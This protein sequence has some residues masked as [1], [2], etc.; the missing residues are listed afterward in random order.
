MAAAPPQR[1]A[2]LLGLLPAPTLESLSAFFE[3]LPFPVNLFHP[4]GTSAFV[5]SAFVAMIQAAAPEYSLLRPE[6]IVE[7]YNILEDPVVIASGRLAGWQAAFAGQTTHFPMIAQPIA[8]IRQNHKMEGMDLVAFYQDVTAFPILAPS[9][10]RVAFVASILITRQ[11]VKGRAEITRGM[12]YLEAHWR[13]PFDADAASEAAGFSVT[14]FA[15]EFKKYLGV[16]PREYHLQYRMERLK[17]RLRDPTVSIARAFSDCGMD[18]SGWHAQSFKDRIGLTPSE[19]RKRES[20]QV[21][22]LTR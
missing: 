20:A 16:T 13:E 6:R 2:A 22:S 8:Q 15:R 21:G 18:Y 9:G 7:S 19:Y 14:H 11:F 5:N 12:D 3:L 4:D 10:D 1:E 17:E